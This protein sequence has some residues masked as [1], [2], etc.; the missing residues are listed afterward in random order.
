VAISGLQIAK[1][2]GAEGMIYLEWDGRA[3]LMMGSD[4]YFEF[5]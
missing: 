2:S 4:H 5:G 1:A 3:V